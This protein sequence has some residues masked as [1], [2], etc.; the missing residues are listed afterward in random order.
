MDSFLLLP[1]S[2]DVSIIHL[3][4]K[5]GSPGIRELFSLTS[6]CPIRYSVP[7][8][9]LPKQTSLDSVSLSTCIPNATP[10][11]GGVLQPQP[12]VDAC[13][14][15]LNPPTVRVRPHPLRTLPCT[16]NQWPHILILSLRPRLPASPLR[17]SLDPELSHRGL[18]LTLHTS[19]VLQVLVSTHWALR[20]WFSQGT[21]EQ[22]RAA[23]RCTSLHVSRRS[24]SVCL[25]L[26][27]PSVSPPPPLSY[28]LIT[29]MGVLQ[30]S[31]R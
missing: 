12:P 25:P 14:V 13:V 1:I 4:A 19:G 3:V 17:V 15:S 26:V 6:P 28:T 30:S 10:A 9:Y 29:F 2:V 22:V 27:R 21:K 24:N 5:V 23:G 16:A 8:P 7:P 18:S 20:P 31:S 11:H